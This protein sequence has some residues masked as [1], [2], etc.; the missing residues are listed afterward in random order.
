MEM[1]FIEF[2][3]TQI[4]SVS[5]AEKLFFCKC[6][7]SG[8]CE[9]CLTD[10]FKENIL[11]FFSSTFHDIKEPEALPKSERQGFFNYKPSKSD[12][13]LTYNGKKIL[14][15]CKPFQ[16][17][18][19]YEITNAFGQLVAY[20]LPP[21]WDEGCLVIFDT[22]KKEYGNNGYLFTAQE[23]ASP[24]D[25][26]DVKLNKW[27]AELFSMQKCPI[28]ERQKVTISIVRIFPQNDD[29]GIE[30]FSPNHTV[31]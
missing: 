6:L 17:D 29:I 20:L 11:K 25:E 22:R 21:K 9:S 4:S 2:L 31:S 7:K 19:L 13:E 5:S 8:F 10:A 30:V 28:P 27:F 18:R 14:L 12:L 3:R 26:L 1:S 16:D 24:K 23:G 15:E